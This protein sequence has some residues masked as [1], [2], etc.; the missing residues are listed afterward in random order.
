MKLGK[1]IATPFS[2]AAAAR[3]YELQGG[4]G[5][6]AI[7][8]ISSTLFVK[9]GDASVDADSA[10]DYGTGYHYVVEVGYKERLSSPTG[11]SPKPTHIS[12]KSAADQDVYIQEIS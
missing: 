11:V 1:K 5:L 4:S 3:L 10:G 6:V 9:W 7:A 2:G 8:A 12:I